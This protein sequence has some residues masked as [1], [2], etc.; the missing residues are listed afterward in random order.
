M[1]TH[2]WSDTITP[3]QD[4]LDLACDT[5]ARLQGRPEHDNGPEIR[6][7][8]WGLGEVWADGDVIA[9]GHLVLSCEF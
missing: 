7:F 6:R 9:Q 4:D 2:V 1:H 5:V 8:S 3:D